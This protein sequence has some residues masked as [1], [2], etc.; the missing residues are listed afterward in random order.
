MLVA[1][2]NVWARAHLNDDAAPDRVYPVE[3]GPMQLSDLQDQAEALL[4][5]SGRNLVENP[6]AISTAP[7]APGPLRIY[8][9]P[10][11]AVASAGDPL[12]EAFKEPQVI[13]PRHRSPGEWLPGARSVVSWFLPFTLRVRAANRNQ[14][15][16]ATEWIYA[17]WEGEMCNVALAKAMEGLLRAWGARAVAPMADPAFRVVDMRSNW[18]ERHAAFAAGLGTFSLS[19]SMITRL[20]AAGRFGSIVTDA[21]L[22]PTPRAYT[23]VAEHCRQCG[24]CIDRCPCGAIDASGKD[25]RICSAYLDST[26]A[27][28]APRY[29]CGKCQTGVPCERAI[30]RPA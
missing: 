14:G 10:L 30:P 28:Y 2:T 23:G 18:S 19:R 25:H 21:L 17:R 15:V 20:G 6:E 26:K 12:W 9:P 22:E 1:D 16:T 24:L 3:G 8:D 4:A 13:G 5:A 29:G 11:L 27:L 7:S